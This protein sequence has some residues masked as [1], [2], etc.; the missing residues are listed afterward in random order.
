[1]AIATDSYIDVELDGDV[2]DRIGLSAALTDI[3]TL[4][5]EC[6]CGMYNNQ[7]L[8]PHI[9]ETMIPD[10]AVV[11]RK[12]P[13]KWDGSGFPIEFSYGDPSGYTAP[14]GLYG[15]VVWLY[16]IDGN[17]GGNAPDYCITS[18]NINKYKV[19]TEWDAPHYVHYPEPPTNVVGEPLRAYRYG[20][21]SDTQT[22]Y[23]IYDNSQGLNFKRLEYWSDNNKTK[24]AEIDDIYPYQ[25]LNFNS[26]I[27]L[28][29]FQYNHSKQGYYDSDSQNDFWNG[30]NVSF[31]RSETFASAL[32]FTHGTFDGNLIENDNLPYSINSYG[33][34]FVG[35]SANGDFIGTVSTGSSN[36]P[37][38]DGRLRL[39]SYIYFHSRDAVYLYTAN[40]GL[41][42]YTDKLYKPI[43]SNGVV[44][45]FTDDMA[46][47]SDL[48]TWTGTTNHGI[49]PTPP[50]PPSPDAG[51]NEIDVDMSQ[52]SPSIGFVNYIEMDHETA[53][54]VAAA[55][56]TYNASIWNIGGDL[57]KNLIS[58][59]IFATYG[60]HSGSIKNIS[61][62]GHELEYNGS[63][64]SGNYIDDMGTVD[65]GSINVGGIFRFNDW[66][67]FAPYTKIECFVPCCG[68][69]QLPPWVMGRTVTG[70]LYI[71]IANGSC[72][73][74]IKAGKTPI[75]EIGGC[76]AVDIPFSS[77]ATGAK[78]AG[79]ISSLAN[80]AVAAFNPTPQNLIS[81]SFGIMSAFNANFTE[82]KGTM[83]DGSNING[84][85]QFLIKVTRPASTDTG[86][87]EITTKYKHEKGLPCAKTKTLANGQGFTQI[88]DANIDGEMTDR[89]KQM[90]IEAFRHGLIL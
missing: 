20:S 85:T 9:Y 69:C 1:M 45:G 19:V 56:N 4:Q 33:H 81:G 5:N 35:V 67:D 8:N 38:A 11:N 59:K 46:T 60:T 58:Y 87:G 62:A 42:F 31:D 28:L 15:G 16:Y 72:K 26:K 54:K 75:A 82:T 89:E 39:E 74:V 23:G 86:N 13:L 84:C 55:F 2:V 49:T 76:C 36:F 70:T 24:Y 65:L 30:N 78:A 37:N 21:W 40:S 10:A 83:G 68:W 61:I 22:Q 17:N 12:A 41:K 27:Y 6:F 48:D 18:Q 52:F 32:A 57:F 64:I 66:R 79:I 88:M 77:V 14:D 34:N 44:T 51:D 73:A 63:P 29:A 90:I 53:L 47:V 43:I 25:I 7:L 50:A 80:G 3:T 71:D